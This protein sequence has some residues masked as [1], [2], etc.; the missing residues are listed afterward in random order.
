MAQR[1]KATL[2][3][4]FETGDAPTGSDFEDLI[5]SSLNLQ[6][7]TAQTINGQISFAGGASFAS[8]SAATVG[9]AQG[10]FTSLNA[11]AASMVTLSVNN[12][13]GLARAEMYGLTPGTAAYA[14]M[15]AFVPLTAMLTTAD[16]AIIQQFTH[17]SSARLTYVGTVTK[18]VNVEVT[19]DTQTV[20]G[21]QHFA[22]R[23]GVNGNTLEKSEVTFMS[24]TAAGATSH[25]GGFGC[26]VT[27][28]ANS[29]I[30][31]WSAAYLNNA[32]VIFTRLNVRVTEA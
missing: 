30:E 15:S 3:T 9:G 7:T 10:T 24:T 22:M 1:D 4:I 20:T 16:S 11:T 23:V 31:V 13:S 19:F 29:F 28:T 6:E 32:N 17:S 8:L 18:V 26:M 2:K 5:D 14:S 12:L 25:G 27:L 21:R